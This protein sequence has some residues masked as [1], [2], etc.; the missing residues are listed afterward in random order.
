MNLMTLDT[1]QARID[2]DAD[3]DQFRGEILSLNGGA[4]KPG[5]VR[6]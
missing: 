3:L 2:Y 5:A 1:Y 6:A 4:A